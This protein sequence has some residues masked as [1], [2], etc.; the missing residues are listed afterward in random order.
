MPSIKIVEHDGVK[1]VVDGHH[2]L[3]AARALKL[4]EIPIAKVELPYKGYKTVMDLQ[5]TF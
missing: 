1:Y 3:Y 2:R 4:S 5:Y